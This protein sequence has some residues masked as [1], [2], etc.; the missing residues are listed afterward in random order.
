MQITLAAKTVLANMRTD[1]MADVQKAAD[2]RGQAD[3]IELTLI[4]VLTSL[5]IGSLGIMMIKDI[6]MTTEIKTKDHKTKNMVIKTR[7]KGKPNQHN[8]NSSP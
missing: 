3:Q 2:Q 5:E 6:K 4:K 7:N 1:L 8:R